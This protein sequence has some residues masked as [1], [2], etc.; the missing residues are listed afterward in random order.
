MT[1]AELQ[2]L[3]TDGEFHHA[4]YRNLA[5]LWE[6]LHIYVKDPAGH[7]GFSHAGIF[8]KNNPELNAA[9]EMVRKTGI[10]VGSYGKG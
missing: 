9:M 6:G 8:L 4:T 2:A 1:I 10:S 7:R 3:M 5:T